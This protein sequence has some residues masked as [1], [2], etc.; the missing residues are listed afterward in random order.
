MATPAK[1]LLYQSDDS[2]PGSGITPQSDSTTGTVF[3]PTGI[4]QARR[5]NGV[6]LSTNAP[7]PLDDFA[8]LHQSL[9]GIL[10]ATAD[11]FTPRPMPKIGELAAAAF[12]DGKSSAPTRTAVAGMQ[13]S[14]FNVNEG[15]HARPFT[16]DSDALTRYLLIKETA[17][18]VNRVLEDKQYVSKPVLTLAVPMLIL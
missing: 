2:T 18:I 11:A 13:P 12:T 7:G 8:G 5:R 6:G 3:S 14:I 17:S 16:D 1:G 15:A 9:T 4:I 10:C